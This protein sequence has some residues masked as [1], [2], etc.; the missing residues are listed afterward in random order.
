MFLLISFSGNVEISAEPKLS[1]L[2]SERMRFQQVLKCLCCSLEFFEL[3]FPKFLS[4]N[5]E[6]RNLWKSLSIQLSV[7]VLWLRLHVWRRLECSLMTPLAAITNWGNFNRAL[8]VALHVMGF[9]E[10]I[11][12]W[13]RCWRWPS[14]IRVDFKCHN[15][16]CWFCLLLLLLLLLYVLAAALVLSR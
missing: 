4:K 12:V 1:K 10:E 14:L 5:I 7:M 3:P 9:E 11:G 6:F 16:L 2:I 8:C 13:R 15:I